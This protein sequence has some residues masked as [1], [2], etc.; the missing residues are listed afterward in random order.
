VVFDNQSRE[1][2]VRSSSM[3][4]HATSWDGAITF[5]NVQVH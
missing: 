2:A 4:Q 1:T 3:I 5:D